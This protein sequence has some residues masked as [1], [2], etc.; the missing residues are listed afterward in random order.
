MITTN[1]QLDDERN[2]NE[3]KRDLEAASDR[4]VAI[5]RR[6]L[7]EYGVTFPVFC[8]RAQEGYPPQPKASK[9]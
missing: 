7:E 3:A 8:A 5:N 9:R 1:D 6:Y 4:M 2:Y